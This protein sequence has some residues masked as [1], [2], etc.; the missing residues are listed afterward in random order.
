MIALRNPA[1]RLDVGAGHLALTRI[2]RGVSAPVAEAG[3][4]SSAGLRQALAA[5]RADSAGFNLP[6]RVAVA[7]A[8]ELLQ[9]RLLR[10]LPPVR[11]AQA[12]AIV[13][14]QVGRFFRQLDGALVIGVAPGPRGTWV[15]IAVAESLLDAVV[16]GLDDAG[17]LVE[18]IRPAAVEGYPP[19]NLLPPRS[20][21]ANRARRQRILWHVGASCAA[22]L[23]LAAVTRGVHDVREL[24]RLEAVADSLRPFMDST[25]EL[26]ARQDEA[27]LMLGTVLG[28]ERNR[29]TVPRLLLQ[30]ARGLP[31]S[32]VL[33]GLTLDGGAGGRMTG[34]ARRPLDLVAQLEQAQ[35]VVRPRIEGGTVKEPLLGQTWDRFTL[36]FGAEGLP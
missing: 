20:R 7:L 18:A 32:V 1:W 15:G 25:A 9:R 17:V 16:A 4:E 27:R 19:V 6:R 12:A 2:T 24:S 21:A 36:A 31:D 10:D 35:V 23:A 3:W 30:L 26:R 13:R 34:L 8:P 22:L 11:A 33:T 28:A 14:H 5:L 29:T